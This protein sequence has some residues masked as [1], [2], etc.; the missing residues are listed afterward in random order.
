M[1]CGCML[2]DNGVEIRI[3]FVP[4]M[5]VVFNGNRMLVTDNC[6]G[7]TKR[8]IERPRYE[9]TGDYKRCLK[10]VT[11]EENIQPMSTGQFFSY[12]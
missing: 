9:V 3:F 7:K 1:E 10:F 6:E 12:F 8:E 4:R 11:L 5:L 2:L